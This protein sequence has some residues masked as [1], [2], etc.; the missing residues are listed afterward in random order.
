MNRTRTVVIM[1]AAL[2]CFMPSIARAP[3]L[4]TA[5]TATATATVILTVERYAVV[6]TMDIL[7]C[8]IQLP[9]P[10]PCSSGFVLIMVHLPDFIQPQDLH[11]DT[12]KI[13]G[14]AMTPICPSRCQIPAEWLP[15]ILKPPDHLLILFFDKS[16]FVSVLGETPGVKT[17]TLEMTIGGGHVLTAT[18]QLSLLAP[19]K[20]KHGNNQHMEHK[21]E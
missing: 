19:E 5:A 14:I 17:V 21:I 2:V 9:L 6:T 3:T 8:S 12:I 13:N 1:L 4:T 20:P 10:K 18:G 16:Q 11:K 15:Y 7:P